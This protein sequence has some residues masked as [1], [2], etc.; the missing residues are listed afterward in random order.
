VEDDAGLEGIG[1]AASAHRTKLVD[2]VTA[3]TTITM[4][5]QQRRP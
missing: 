4:R 1:L 3:R 2:M 5:N